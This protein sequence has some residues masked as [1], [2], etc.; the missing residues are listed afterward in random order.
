MKYSMKIADFYITPD[1]PQKMYYTDNKGEL[2]IGEVKDV[3][4]GGTYEV[5]VGEKRL[6]TCYRYI[7]KWLDQD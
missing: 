3:N 7:L 1:D 5:E 2:F 6:G 4:I